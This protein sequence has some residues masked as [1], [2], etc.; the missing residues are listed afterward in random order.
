MFYTLNVGK[1]YLVLLDFG[2]CILYFPKLGK[3]ISYFPKF[4]NI[5][6]KVGGKNYVG[7]G[8]M[9]KRHLFF[10]KTKEKAWWQM[11]PPPLNGKCPRFF[12]FLLSLPYNGLDVLVQKKLSGSELHCCCFY[13]VH[14]MFEIASFC[15]VQDPVLNDWIWQLDNCTTIHNRNAPL[16]THR[17]FIP[18]VLALAIIVHLICTNTF[19]CM[20]H[21]IMHICDLCVR[22]TVQCISVQM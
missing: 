20:T 4:G 18:N 19:V 21:C 15:A 1:I 10:V 9:T 7:R 2:K 8:I 6:S 3:T 12:P 17:A 22:C 11:R 5:F 13:G 14:W 16:L